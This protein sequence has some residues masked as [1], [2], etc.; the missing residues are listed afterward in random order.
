MSSIVKELQKDSMKSDIR[1]SDLLRKALFVARKLEIKEFED[2][3]TQELNGYHGEEIPRYRQI[4]GSPKYFNPFYGYQDFNIDHVEINDTIST[5]KLGAPLAELEDLHKNSGNKPLVHEILP[6]IQSLFQKGFQTDVVPE[7]VFISP[8]AIAGVFDTIRNMI[9][10]WSM[11]LEEDGILGE[12]FDFNEDEEEIAHQQSNVY[13]T[14]ISS[15]SNIQI[16]EYNTQNI[17]EIDLE[18]VKGVLTLIRNSIESFGLNDTNKDVLEGEL[19][20]MDSQLES[21]NPNP[22]LLKEGL[23]S[24]R[25]ILEGVSISTT[26]SI[27]IPAITKMIGL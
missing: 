21:T 8:S 19:V 27:L 15:S 24:I 12:N 7:K 16:G 3:I 6:S 25:S 9:F 1:L 2:W 4:K 18:D 14:M 10:E 22:E 20:A 26:A 17:S 23:K 11:K 5:V 13:N